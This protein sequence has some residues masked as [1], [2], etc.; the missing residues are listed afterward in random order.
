M[1]TEQITKEIEGV[2]S[3]G[4]NISVRVKNPIIYR[5]A[6][7]IIS[8][9]TYGLTPEPEKLIISV[10]GEYLSIN[11]TIDGKK[12][13][14]HEEC[15]WASKQQEIVGSLDNLYSAVKNFRE[16]HSSYLN[17]IDSIDLL[18]R[19]QDSNNNQIYDWS[20][21]TDSTE[22][23]DKEIWGQ[24]EKSKE[25][26]NLVYYGHEL[27]EDFF[28]QNSKL[29]ILLNSLK[30]GTI[31][32]INWLL[33]S[34][35]T[36]RSHVPWGLMFQQPVPDVGQPINPLG[37]IGLRYRME[38]IAHNPDGKPEALGSLNK[39]NRVH[40]LYWGKKETEIA[41]EAEW[42]RTTLSLK[43][44]NQEFVPH[45]R[46]TN[47]KNDLLNSLKSP[48]PNP[49]NLLYLYCVCDVGQGNTPVLRFG[50]NNGYSNI[51]Q[52][53]DMSQEEFLERP[54]VFANACTTLAS[55][56]YMANN[57]E[58]TFFKRGCAA[59]LG[60]ES[61][62]PII[63]ASRFAIVFFHFFY[64]TVNPKKVAAGEAVVQTRL[65]LWQHYKNIGGLFYSYVGPYGLYIDP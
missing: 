33:N 15:F 37:F 54:L 2:K 44:P 16:A 1:D 6:A 8:Q 41:V 27:Y 17:N 4:K 38:Y 52:Q 42:L 59:Y 55:S 5:S 32:E 40:Y 11:G 3:S 35:L 13:C 12:H 29:Y 61:E 28:P 64:H 65:F 14:F 48:T 24:V 39:S 46:V 10:T 22:L 18:S 62:V 21:C 49:V 60:T 19:L 31:I 20:N 43:W 56:P 57:L 53:T 26:R 30:P 25:L 36:W 50:D 23:E 58:K 7:D 51:V 45:M 34:K 9:P 47:Q 63:L